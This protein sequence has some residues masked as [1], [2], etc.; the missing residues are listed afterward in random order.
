MEAD[1]NIDSSSPKP[2]RNAV[3]GFVRRGC[4][5]TERTTDEQRRRRV[6]TVATVGAALASVPVASMVIDLYS[7]HGY[8]QVFSP[9]LL[10]ILT[11]TLFAH[12]FVRWAMRASS[13][14]LVV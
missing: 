10:P 8:H 12:L 14:A 7:L 11:T 13:T 2:S 4:M 3:G 6:A 9:A 1:V 5:W